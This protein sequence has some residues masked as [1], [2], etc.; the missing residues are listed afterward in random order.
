ML[1]PQGHGGKQ[2]Y[3]PN[4]FH[5]FVQLHI[6]TRRN[7]TTP[8][9]RQPVEIFPRPCIPPRNR[10]SKLA[11]LTR[12]KKTG[13]VFCRTPCGLMT[14]TSPRKVRSG[15]PSNFSLAVCPERRS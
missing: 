11:T 7:I 10:L 3:Q 9:G 14:A 13:S 12:A 15:K 2:S 8:A 4:Q 6:P 5:S 1:Y